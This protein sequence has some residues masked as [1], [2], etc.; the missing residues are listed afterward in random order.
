M[1]IF[2]C[3]EKGSWLFSYSYHCVMVVMS[4]ITAVVAAFIK[5]VS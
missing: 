5:L 2:V 3:L 4:E 1:M